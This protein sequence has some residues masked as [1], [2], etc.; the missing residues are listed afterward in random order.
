MIENAV[1]VLGGV[2][3]MATVTFMQRVVALT[4]AATD[5][6]H[7]NLLVSQHST[8][9]DRTAYLLGRSDEDPLP[10]M[11]ADAQSLEAAGVRA[12]AMPCNTA[13]HFHSELAASV[14][15]PFL[16]IITETIGLAQRSHPGL[17]KLG[18]LAT[19]GTLF[20]RTYQLACEERG[21]E[22]V[23]P[24]SVYQTDVM[25]VIYNHVKAGRPVQR[26]RFDGMV[27]HL[28]ERDAEAVVLGCTEL[29]ILGHDLGIAPDV[30]DSLDALAL[31][32]IEV[33]GKSVKRDV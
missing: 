30:V 33:S 21:I 14:S 4:E 1:G 17:R 29:S 32:T 22:C 13:D 8:I 23:V 2:G 10:V 19:D 5:Q 26:E 18:I 24:L 11:V 16:S 31:K 9:P 3:P 28:L 27:T 20:A 12:I 25:D 15:I 7:V 6:E